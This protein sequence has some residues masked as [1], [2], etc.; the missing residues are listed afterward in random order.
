MG[1]E[2]DVR[3]RCKNC[4]LCPEGQR[5]NT[6]MATAKCLNRN[7][8]DSDYLNMEI[9]NGVR[10]GEKQTCPAWQVVPTGTADNLQDHSECRSTVG[11]GHNDVCP[12]E[13]ITA[14]PIGGGE[15]RISRI[16]SGITEEVQ[17][18]TVKA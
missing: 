17:I 10:K 4:T 15:F 18:T 6:D 9:T 16:R 7:S 11:E 8:E 14:T 13:G 3:I 12:Y 5:K 1:E 2:R